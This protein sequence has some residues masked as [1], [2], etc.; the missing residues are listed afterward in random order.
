MYAIYK[1][2]GEVVVTQKKKDYESLRKYINRHHPGTSLYTY[3]HK[4][5]SDLKA[6]VLQK[7]QIAEFQGHRTTD[8]QQ[9]YGNTRSGRGGRSMT[10]KGYNEV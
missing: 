7:R 4:V 9:Y 8:S 1:A 10:A 2:V 6:S 3:S 5:A